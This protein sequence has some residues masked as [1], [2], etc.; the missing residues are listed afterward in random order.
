MKPKK[1]IWGIVGSALALVCAAGVVV[2]D[3]MVS[4]YASMINLHF[5]SETKSKSSLTEKE[6]L[7]AARAFTE[8]EE[9]EGLVMLKNNGI[10]PL[11][12]TKINVFGNC[13]VQNL[14][15]G[16]GSA[17]SWFKQEQN[18]TL[19][20]GLE[21]AG[22]EV[23]PG[24]IQFYTDNLQER[25]DQSGG[26][27]NMTGADASI[28]EERLSLYE[29][30]DYDNQNILDYS[31]NFSDTA[32]YVIGRAGGEGSDAKFDMDGVTGGDKGKHYFQLQQV[33]LELL[34]YLE[35]NYANVIILL[36]TPGQMEWDITHDDKIDAA[37]WIGMPGSTGFNAV[38]DVLTGKISPSGHTVDTWPYLFSSD[39]T[40]Y[41]FGDY[42]YANFTDPLN[43]NRNHYVY[44]NEGIYVGY[45]YYETAAAANAIRY[46]DI[47]QYPFGF[48][49]SYTTFTWSDAK[50][51]VGGKGGEITVTVTVT[52]TGKTYSGKDVV[53]LYY[54]APYNKNEGIEKS[55][56]VLGAFAKTKELKPGESDKVTLTMD[57]D[58]M[59]SYDYRTAK[60]YVLSAGDYQLSLRSDSHTI[61]DG[62]MIFLSIPRL[63]MTKKVGNENRIL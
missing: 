19:L 25:Q 33:E 49:L 6:T 12:K 32:I 30:Y 56:V 61:K 7:S 29:S 41:N 63:S 48:G 15:Q 23:N 37:L 62:L 20:K 34:D 21:N 44:Y 13:S 51:K 24:L 28:F 43:H 45:R 60:A 36:N 27:A 1:K 58:A 47:V 50:W 42:T 4:R 16:S 9:G 52:N 55:A 2:A 22:F 38:G 18:V 5:R 57:Y 11:R 39:P 46:G 31:K 17:S 53:E 35:K 14:Y 59:A 3:V 40:Y 54:S 26:K 10:L 8:K